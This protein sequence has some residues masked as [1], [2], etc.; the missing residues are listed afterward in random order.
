MIPNR[1]LL[2]Q[3][4]SSGLPES[5]LRVARRPTGQVSPCHV[6]APRERHKRPRYTASRVVTAV[7]P[8]TTLESNGQSLTY[9]T[10]ARSSVGALAIWMRQRAGTIC[11]GGGG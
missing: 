11:L 6:W 7:T 3:Q 2:Q 10:D 1:N 5:H 9:G 4:P 8:V